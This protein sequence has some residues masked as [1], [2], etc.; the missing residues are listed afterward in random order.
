VYDHGDLTFF[1]KKFLALF[2]VLSLFALGCQGATVEETMEGET[3]TEIDDTDVS[4]VVEPIPVEEESLVKHYSDEFLSFDYPK[5][6]DLLVTSYVEGPL[7]ETLTFITFNSTTGAYEALGAGV[8]LTSD[9]TS[10]R[11]AREQF[12]FDKTDNAV[13]LT[14][15]NAEAYQIHYEADMCDA[16]DVVH[17]LTPY[18]T[19]NAYQAG[20]EIHGKFTPSLCSG[21]DHQEVLD[22]FLETVSFE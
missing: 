18:K 7:G 5:D 1:M 10:G 11:D 20:L 9:G 8:T 19:D 12:E 16:Y 15:E 3:E 14:I 21:D 4:N 13:D 6:V 2:F 17:F 22:L